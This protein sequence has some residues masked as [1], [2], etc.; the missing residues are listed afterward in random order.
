[1]PEESPFV[2]LFSN[3]DLLT[4][5]AHFWPRPAGERRYPII[6]KLYRTDPETQVLVEEQFPRDEPRGHV[7]LVHG[8]ESSGR[9][10]YMRSMAHAAAEAGFAAHRLNLRSC[11]GTEGLCRTA[12][13]SGMTADLRSV[14]EQLP[15]PV[16][17]AGFSLGGNVALKLAGEWGDSAAGRVAGVCAV[18]TPIDL[19]ASVAR[20]EEPRNRVYHKRFV[21]SLKRRIHVRH[22]LLPE[23]FPVEG[24]DRIRSIREFD[25]WFTAPAFGFR[26]AADY[27]QTQSAV[28]FMHRIRIP[29]LL[30]Q[31]KDDPVVPFESF[32]NPALLSNPCIRLIAT[33]HGGHIGFLARRRPRFWLDEVIV[34]W[35]SSLAAVTAA[36]R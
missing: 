3:P 20:I 16:F 10:G 12:Y 23:K 33:E 32:Q 14:I 31:A 25:D 9:S 6:Q 11:G 7:V 26:N 28:R 5:A 24:L 36:V 13:H 27:Y 34:D 1:M 21:R 30:I 8:L 15:P 4:I 19:A 17:I 2:P 35:I 29:T 22:A 18:S